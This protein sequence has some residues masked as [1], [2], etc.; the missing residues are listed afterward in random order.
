M[1]RKSLYAI[2]LGSSA[3]GLALFISGC[4]SQSDPSTSETAD[5][6]STSTTSSPVVVDTAVAATEEDHAHKPGAHGGI[7]V[8]IGRDSYHAEAV[9]EKGGKLRLFTL[10]QD[11][12]RIQEVEAQTLT[13]YVKAEGGTDAVS[14]TLEPTRLSGDAQ[15]K[16][17]QFVGTLP[18]ELIGVPVE[19][20]IPSLMIA[21]ERFRLG[22]SSVNEH[23]WLDGHGMPAKVADGEERDLYLTPGGHYTVAD[24]E[25][26][27]QMTASQKFKGIRASHDM[28]PKPGDRLCPIM[29]TKANAK[30]SWVVGGKTYE[31]CCPPC[32]DEFLVL[33]K[34]GGDIGEPEDY[35]KEAGDTK[36]SGN[37]KTTEESEA[38]GGAEPP[39]ATAS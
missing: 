9:F 6:E 4:G 34:E 15:G 30:F 14:F 31:F 1:F 7:I 25:A 36:A 3:L 13:A 28:N 39:V 26:N 2:L 23:E 33:A 10:G 24:I 21:G 22:F 19:V 16:T 8:A 11:E 32:V 27:G 17:S 12:G 35:V 29:M 37:G 18:D 38:G 5:T 20:T